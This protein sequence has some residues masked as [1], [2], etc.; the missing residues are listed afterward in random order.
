MIGCSTNQTKDSGE[1]IK[2]TSSTDKEEKQ[3]ED[4]TKE[5]AD[6]Q[7]KKIE[8]KDTDEQLEKN[9]KNAKKEAE[10]GQLMIAKMEIGSQFG[11]DGNMKYNHTE[12]EVVE[13]FMDEDGRIYF[14]LDDY[15][16]RSIMD[17]EGNI[18]NMTNYSDTYINM[19][20]GLAYTLPEDGRVYAYDFFISNPPEELRDKQGEDYRSL[21]AATNLER[22]IMQI[23]LL[24]VDPLNE[25]G[26]LIEQDIY[27]G[28]IFDTIRDEF[29]DLGNPN[30]LIPA[31]QTVLDMQL[32]ENMQ[33]IQGLWGELGKFERPEQNKA[34]FTALY[35]ALRQE[36]NH[37]VIR[38]N[39]TLSEDLEG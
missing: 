37:I 29:F 17:E 14:A 8:K 11:E 28:D 7:Q 22:G 34:E 20:E 36:M 1:D 2:A 25:L 6:Q 9:A 21:E 35:Q 12:I 33:M 39:Y 3:M 10:N 38:V 19:L 26:Y 24:T 30:V 16:I 5:D 18:S 15:P 31:P 27:D 32:Y 13:E 4:E 23:V